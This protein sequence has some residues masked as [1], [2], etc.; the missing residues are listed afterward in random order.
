MPYIV[1][2]ETGYQDRDQYA[3]AV[4]YDPSK[5]FDAVEPAGAAGTTSC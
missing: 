1:R 2:V 4:L 5:P 3:I